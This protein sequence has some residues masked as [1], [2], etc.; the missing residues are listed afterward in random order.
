MR[1]GETQ[2]CDTSDLA[3]SLDD[4]REAEKRGREAVGN[5]LAVA[6]ILNSAFSGFRGFG[7]KGNSTKGLDTMRPGPFA[8]ASIPARSNS[9][10]FTKSER[11]QINE[12]GDKCGCHACGAKTSG[13][14]TGNWTPDHQPVSKMVPDGTPQRPFPIANGAVPSRG[15][16]AIFQSRS[17]MKFEFVHYLE[18]T[19]GDFALL[20]Q[21][22]LS[23]LGGQPMSS[24]T[25][26]LTVESECGNCL[27]LRSEQSL[28]LL[29]AVYSPEGWVGALV[30]SGVV[31]RFEEGHKRV[32]LSAGQYVFGDVNALGR[33]KPSFVSSPENPASTVSVSLVEEHAAVAVEVDLDEDTRLVGVLLRVSTGGE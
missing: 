18:S 14:A 7:A 5:M 27:V 31:I 23:R 9:Q 12:I 32:F 20:E 8:R 16:R 28:A 17:C 2:D 15:T 13:R 25:A 26:G 4:L 33:E 1:C 22:E 29:E 21:S 19:G 6:S 10:S 24:I 11:Q 30:Q 3:K